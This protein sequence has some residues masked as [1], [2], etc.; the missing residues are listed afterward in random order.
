[1]GRDCLLCLYCE[2]YCPEEAVTSPVIRP[3]FAPFMKYNVHHASRDP[4]LEYVRVRRNQGR[5]ERL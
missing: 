2:M 1:M 3:L 5:V 4:A